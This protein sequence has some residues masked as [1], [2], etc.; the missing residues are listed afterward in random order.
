MLQLCHWIHTCNSV[1]LIL[2]REIELSLIFLHLHTYIIHSIRHLV[3]PLK[4]REVQHKGQEEEGQ[5]KD[6]DQETGRTEGETERTHTQVSSNESVRVPVCTVHYTIYIY[7]IYII[8][9]IQY[10]CTEH[11]TFWTLC[12]HSTLQ[13]RTLPSLFPH[14]R[15]LCICV[16]VLHD[17]SPVCIFKCAIE[18]RGKFV[19]GVL[20]CMRI[21]SFECPRPGSHTLLGQQSEGGVQ[22]YLP[23]LRLHSNSVSANFK[24]TLKPT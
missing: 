4:K 17:F 1:R 21:P 3:I 10:T 6:D 24:V 13:L 19:L 11:C 23:N 5:R 14:R 16:F 22:V 9:T 15:S 8:Y 2:S 7:S 18:L 12:T 20:H